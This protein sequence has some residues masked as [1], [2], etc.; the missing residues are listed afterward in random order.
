MFRSLKLF[1][2]A[3]LLLAP[4]CGESEPA[5]PLIAGAE[6]L[7][8]QQPERAREAAQQSDPSIMAIVAVLPV[9]QLALILEDQEAGCPLL[10]DESDR[11]SGT[12]SWRIEGDCEGENEAGR[13]RVDGIIVAR[14]DSD[15]TDIDY[16]G[17]RYSAGDASG[18]D[19]WDSTL[20]T[21]GAVRLPYAYML[22]AGDDAD[23]APD[24]DEVPGA[25]RYLLDVYL[26]RSATDIESCAV[27]KTEIAYDVT[28][29]RRFERTDPAGDLADVSDMK[30]RVA[31]LVHSRESAQGAWQTTWNGDWRVSADDYGSM[32]GG[33][34]CDRHATGTLR[35]ESG[36]DVAVIQPSAPVSCFETRADACTAWSL[37]GEAQPEMCDFLGQSGCSA[38]P[39][40]PPPWAAIILLVGGLIWQ[41]RRRQRI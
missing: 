17:F 39:D 13:Y 19:G 9:L 11:S 30:G 38:G 4:G 12:V 32:D 27:E 24:E 29:D 15:R 21:S 2:A 7:N 31:M 40:A 6:P 26:E 41:S 23:D 25:G 1:L 34:D 5:G 37:N 3:T 35:L 20:L 8:L 28:I 22:P 10:V 14:G 18:C 16:R 36:D 33:E